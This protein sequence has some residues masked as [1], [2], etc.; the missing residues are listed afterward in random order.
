MS[1]PAMRCIVNKVG[2]SA[3]VSCLDPR[4]RVMNIVQARELYAFSVSSKIFAVKAMTDYSVK[5]F[6][7]AVLMSYVFVGKTRSEVT[8]D[9]SVIHSGIE[10]IVNFSCSS[11]LLN[12]LLHKGAQQS[13]TNMYSSPEKRFY[14]IKYGGASVVW[15]GSFAEQKFS[16]SSD[17][18]AAF[19]NNLSDI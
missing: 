9:K 15:G 16:R 1:E 17:L 11:S 19:I 8:V 13:P 18:P 5:V 14:E 4:Q 10:D 6:F 3:S 2:R 7:V 12:L